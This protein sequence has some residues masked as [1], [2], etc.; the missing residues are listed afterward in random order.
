MSSSAVLPG[1]FVGVGAAVGVFKLAANA[2]A[3][4]EGTFSSDSGDISR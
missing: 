4:A 3:H 2:S 1:G